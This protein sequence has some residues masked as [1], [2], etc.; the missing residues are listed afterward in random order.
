MRAVQ[1]VQLV[2]DRP[3]PDSAVSLTRRFAAL[4]PCGEAIIPTILSPSRISA[5]SYRN[6]QNTTP[7]DQQVGSGVPGWPTKCLPSSAV[8][9]ESCRAYIWSLKGAFKCFLT[10]TTNSPG[11][12]IHIT[13]RYWEENWSRCIDTILE[14]QLLCINYPSLANIS[15][16]IVS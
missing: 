9:A 10:P 11:V 15:R 2:G 8:L 16:S 3:V 13:Q 12:V 5:R 4:G 7:P 1:R 6:I 14:I